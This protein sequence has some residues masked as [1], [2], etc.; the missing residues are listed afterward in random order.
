M[1]QAAAWELKA[2]GELGRYVN[3]RGFKKQEWR[4]EGRPIIRIQ[5]LTGSSDVFN[6]FDG[7][8]DERHVV[9]PGDLL[10]SWAATLGAYFWRGSEAVLNQ[11]I[12]K[13]ESYIDPRFH[14]YLLDHKFDEMMLHTHGSGMVHI[15][16]GAFDSISV[17]IPPLS[18]QRRIVTVLEDHLSRLDA[19]DAYLDAARRRGMILHDQLLEAKLASVKSEDVAFAD[20]LTTGLANGKSVPTQDGGFPVLRLTALRHGKLDLSERKSGAWTAEDASR[21][22]VRRGDFLISRGNGSLRLVGRGGLVIGEPDPVAFPDT[23]IRARPQTNRITAEF[24][25][26]VWNSPRVRRQIEKAAKTTA[27]IYKVNQTDLNA[28][29]IPVP[30]LEDQ[31][32]LVESVLKSRDALTDVTTESARSAKRSSALRRSL[33][34]AAFSGH[35]T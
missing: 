33:L 30:S 12:F 8:A 13:V 3:G 23:L 10:V 20:L 19:A 7:I 29:L 2:L 22:L 27:G 26:L 34:T 24:L 18:E 4:T 31:G 5:N 9:Q 11:H 28:V 16:R 35:L 32:R 25:A 6:Y 1:T 21:F 15:T 17:A 14:K